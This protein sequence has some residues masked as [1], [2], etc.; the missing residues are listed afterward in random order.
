[1]AVDCLTALSVTSKKLSHDSLK[2][3]LNAVISLRFPQEALNN[4]HIDGSR[5][6]FKET[7]KNFNKD[8]LIQISFNRGMKNR[9]YAG[10]IKPMQ[11][12]YKREACF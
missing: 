5:S 9:S 4:Q 7:G 1:M 8:F 11:A 6:L 3:R 12:S 10:F 2:V